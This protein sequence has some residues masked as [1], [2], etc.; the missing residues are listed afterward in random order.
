MF[1]SEGY[2]SVFRTSITNALITSLTN[3]TRPAAFSPAQHKSGR[4]AGAWPSIPLAGARGRRRRVSW[5]YSLNLEC[6]DKL[7]VEQEM[8]RRRATAVREEGQ[9]YDAVRQERRKKMQ[10]RSQTHKSLSAGSAIWG[11]EGGA[12]VKKKKRKCDI[13]FLPRDCLGAR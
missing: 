11:R 1:S 3:D 5:N 4:R 8:N 7:R 13:Q 6:G 2:R 12:T 9:K 10:E